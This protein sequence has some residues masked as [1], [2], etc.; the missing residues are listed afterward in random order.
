VSWSFNRALLASLALGSVTLWLAC[1]GGGLGSSS[2]PINQPPAITSI[3]S[4]TFR[5]GVAGSFVVTAT[6]TPTPTLS[7]TGTLP[8]GVS[9]NAATGVLS[10]TPAA[11]TGGTYNIMFTAASTGGTSATQ[12]FTL[13]VDNPTPSITFISPPSVNAGAPDTTIT[14]VGSGLVQQ[15]VVQANRAALVT[16]FGSSTQSTATIPA[17]MMVN[18]GV[19][20]ITVSNPA[21]GGGTSDATNF[22]IWPSYPRSNATSVLRNS[23]PLTVI[24]VQGTVESVLDWTSKDSGGTQEDVIAADHSLAPMGIPNIDTTDL[25]TARS[26]PFVAVAGVLDTSSK[27]SSSEISSLV[28]YVQSG[29]T[30][31]LWRPAVTP[32]LTSLGLTGFNSYSGVALRPLTFDVSQPDPMLRYIDNPVEVN[33]QLTVPS[34]STTLGYLAGSCTTLAT[35]STGDAAVLNC[36]LGSGRAYIFGWR[37]HH[38]LTLAERQIVNGTAPQDTNV[39]VLGADICRLLMRGSYE[40]IAAKPQVRAFTPGGHHAA[41]I[42]THD[43]DATTSYSF[44]PEFANLETSLGFKSTFN[45]TTNPYNNGWIGPLYIASGMDSIQYALNQGFDAEDHSFGHFPDFNTAPFGTGSETAGNYMPMYSSTTASTSGMS[46]LGELGVS[47]WLL[48][49]DFG[50]TVESF[51]SGYLLLPTNF[52]RA[53]TETGYVRDSSYAAGFTQGSFPFVTISVNS[54]IVTSYPVME[55]PIAISDRG[56]TTTTESQIVSEWSTVIQ[57]NYANDAPTV[58][59]LHPVDGTLRI[60]ALRDLLAAVSGLDLWIG[61]LKTFAHF[62]ESQGVTSQAVP[63]NVTISMTPQNTTVYVG[64]S[65]QFKP[66]E[67]GTTTLGLVAPGPAV[68]NGR[69]YFKSFDKNVYFL[70]VDGQ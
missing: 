31:Y 17:T 38:I 27:L 44:V 42:I 16:V 8:S 64:A 43:V 5:V 32:L 34:S 55:Y 45:F 21:P 39:P 36:A 54:G 1:G 11:G 4:A 7:E 37:L 56:L 69:F 67:S 13:T 35:W 18:T 57:A 33:W 41:L 23:P 46:A 65:Q 24:P 66:T 70:S 6:G 49:N 14:V 61:D 15:S 2:A 59:L 12:S 48:E 19:L 10:G 58:L 22:K 60:Q 26:N 68:S 63:L 62:W 20:P 53:V 40:G 47:R 30:L 50:I 28:S 3:N 52:L 9:F 29:G 51:R 25:T